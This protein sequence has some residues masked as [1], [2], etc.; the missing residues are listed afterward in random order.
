MLN[1]FRSFAVFYRFIIYFFGGFSKLAGAGWWNGANLWRALT[2]PPFH[3]VDPEIV[4]RW[5]MF[6]PA[7]GL[8]ICGLEFFYPIFIWPRVTRN[9]WM[10]GVCLMHAMIGLT[11]GMYLFASIMIILNRAAF[12][13]GKLW[14]EKELRGKC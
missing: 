14:R 6:L 7:T 10:L 11:M 12:G 1:S 2:V 5:K 4:V 13:P 8:V 3:F 9:F